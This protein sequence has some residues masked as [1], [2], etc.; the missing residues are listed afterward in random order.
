VTRALLCK[1]KTIC[2][3]GQGK[4]YPNGIASRQICASMGSVLLIVSE[5]RRFF[6]KE[7]MWQYQAQAFM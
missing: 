6:E 7:E 2:S 5:Q 1:S 3:N 4:N